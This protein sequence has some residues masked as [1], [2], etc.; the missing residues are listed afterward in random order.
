[1]AS[2]EARAAL[3]RE[4]GFALQPVSDVSLAPFQTSSL[5]TDAKSIKNSQPRFVSGHSAGQLGKRPLSLVK[6]CHCHNGPKLL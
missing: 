4:S 5:F 1:M 6:L 2:A 3:Y